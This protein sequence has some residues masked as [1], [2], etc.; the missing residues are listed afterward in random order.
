M[1]TG[2]E[3]VAAASIFRAKKK[4]FLSNTGYN[5]PYYE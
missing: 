4:T 1:F 5:L 3:E 2:F